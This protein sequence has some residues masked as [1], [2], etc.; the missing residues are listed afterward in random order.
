[1]ARGAVLYDN[2]LTRCT[3]VSTGA[4]VSTELSG[5]GVSRAI[6]YKDYTVTRVSPASGTAYHTI[7][8][9][10][11]T[12][13]ETIDSVAALSSVANC[14]GDV[15]MAYDESGVGTSFTAYTPTSSVTTGK[16]NA[17]WVTSSEIVL[18]TGSLIKI[19]ARRASATALPMDLRQ[20][21]VGKALVFPIGQ[22][23]GI[24]PAILAQGAQFVSRMSVNGS[25]IGRDIVRREISATIEL[26]YLSAAFA[27]GEWDSFARHAER[28]PFFYTSDIDAPA[29]ACWASA[30]RVDA[31]E[32]S[33]PVPLVKVSMPLS[34]IV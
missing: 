6:D 32:N 22:H 1:M 12:Q 23:V 24:R 9:Y 31:P 27:A 30:D 29:L 3:L 14:I 20:V 11:T 13:S 28:L 33:T 17:A 25:L 7:A 19:E 21:F 34:V 2:V 18:P 16:L 15:R 4:N 26:D 5:F 10:E 8:T